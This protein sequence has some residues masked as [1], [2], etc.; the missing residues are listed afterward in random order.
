MGSQVINHRNSHYSNATPTHRESRLAQPPQYNYVHI[1]D[2][3]GDIVCCDDC[4][5]HEGT[6]NICTIVIW[7]AFVFFI[8][9]R[10]FL[11]MSIYLHKG[12]ET[13]VAVGGDNFTS[14]G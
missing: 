6:K 14:P 9:N 5:R 10:F 1:D 2:E 8:M 3:E 7:A 12:E 13:K 4:F 11:H